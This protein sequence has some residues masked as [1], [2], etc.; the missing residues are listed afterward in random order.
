MCGIGGECLVA[1]FHSG[2][3]HKIG[4]HW[5]PICPSFSLPNIFGG[6]TGISP[7]NFGGLTGD[8]GKEIDAKDGDIS[9]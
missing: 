4:E 7:N 2:M 9:N 5:W 8:T 6:L 1:K 3:C